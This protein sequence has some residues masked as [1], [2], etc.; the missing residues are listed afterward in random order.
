MLQK[1]PRP[2]VYSKQNTQ[3]SC[4][5]SQPAAKPDYNWNLRWRCHWLPDTRPIDRD[6]RDAALTDQFNNGDL[7]VSCTTHNIQPTN[8]LSSTYKQASASYKRRGTLSK[9]TENLLVAGTAHTRPWAPRRRRTP[10]HQTPNTRKLGIDCALEAASN[11]GHRRCV[12]CSPSCPFVR[13]L[14]AVV[15]TGE[16]LKGG[17]LNKRSSEQ[18]SETKTDTHGST[19]NGYPLVPNCVCAAVRRYTDTPIHEPS[20][21]PSAT[22]I[23]LRQLLVVLNE[24]TRGGFV[25]LGGTATKSQSGPEFGRGGTKIN[26]SLHRPVAQTTTRVGSDA[27]RHGASSTGA[28]VMGISLGLAQLRRPRQWRRQQAPTGPMARPSSPYPRFDRTLRT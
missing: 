23:A 1:A 8:H 2:A 27:P 9:H 10:K 28:R 12:C 7:Q 5:A 3:T 19:P 14:E 22:D 20:P 11:T 26:D 6:C 25:V 15:A 21:A 17:Y 13:H 4:R 24:Q 18:D 16:R